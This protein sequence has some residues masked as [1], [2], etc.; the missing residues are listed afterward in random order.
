ME[1]I[2]HDGLSDEEIRRILSM[3]RIAVVGM[4]RDPAKPAHYVPKYLL[5]HGYEIV[6]V[7]PTAEEILGLKVYKSLKEVPGPVDI[8]DVFRP[9]EAVP[10]VVKEAVELRPK[11]IW[12]QEGIYHPDAVGLARSRGIT[13]VWNRCMMK[14]HRRLM[15]G[16]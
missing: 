11:V 10:E 8:V 14:E 7:N 1:P 2:P 9:S 16:R 5:E 3:K 4:S 6:P 15:A 13:I 12:L